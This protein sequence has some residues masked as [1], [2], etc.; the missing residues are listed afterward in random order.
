[1]Y[2]AGGMLSAAQH[3]PPFTFRAIRFDAAVD[4]EAMF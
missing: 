1:M 3:P 4:W 2:P